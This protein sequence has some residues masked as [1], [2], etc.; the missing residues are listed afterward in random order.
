MLLTSPSV[1]ANFLGAGIWNS[2]SKVARRVFL[3][4]G[5]LVCCPVFI[6]APL[7]RAMP[8]ASLLLSVVLAAGGYY[9]LIRP[10]SQIWGDLL[11]GF[12][13][14]WLA[15]AIY[16]GWFR[17]QPLLHLPIEAA[18]LPFVLYALSK[19]KHKIGGLF[20]LGS[21]IGTIITDIYFFVTGLIPYWREIMSVQ[22]SLAPP[23]LHQALVQ[24][25]NTWG[26][27]W[28]VVL[29]NI[30]LA[31]GI[32]AIQQEKIYWWGFAGAV[33][34]TLLVDGLFWLVAYLV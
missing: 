29:T 27:S 5:F 26:I 10:K 13:Y 4:S 25:Q 17:W 3:A 15:G 33:L 24:I 2:Q 1:K 8:L 19:G 23:I 16:W 14:S 12:S 9:L 30:L 21:L 6:E 31:V 22:E 32:W 34:S 28:A 18:C 7:V 11:V 20:Y